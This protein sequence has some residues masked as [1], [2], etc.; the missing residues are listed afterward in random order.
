MK[1]PPVMVKLII[2]SFIQ[3]RHL[4][5]TKG[6]LLC[7]TVTIRP[8]WVMQQWQ[9]R[10]S[11]SID[12]RERGIGTYVVLQTCLHLWKRE[13]ENPLLNYCQDL[14]ATFN[15]TYENL[16]YLNYFLWTYGKL[17]PRVWEPK[18]LSVNLGKA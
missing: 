16:N 4:E 5:V 12:K 10:Q 17:Q 14:P 18:L 9:I 7:N 1:T 8:P 15:V 3:L 6:I 2:T 11:K 13:I